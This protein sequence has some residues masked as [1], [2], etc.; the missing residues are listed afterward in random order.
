VDPCPHHQLE[1]ER[2]K[3]RLLLLEGLCGI[4]EGIQ[5]RSLFR[6]TGGVLVF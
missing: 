5:N 4:W 1:F 2:E 6:Y 3:G